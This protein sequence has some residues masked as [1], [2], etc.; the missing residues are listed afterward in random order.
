M[1]ADDA[2]RERVKATV[3]ESLEAHVTDGRLE[4]ASV[5]WLVQAERGL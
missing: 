2:L 4:L 1:G 5:V 3:R